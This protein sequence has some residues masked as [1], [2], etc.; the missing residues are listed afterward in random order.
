MLK[1]PCTGHEA[2]I[3]N[4]TGFFGPLA[5]RPSLDVVYIPKHFSQVNST[6]AFSESYSFVRLT[7]SQCD[8]Q[9]YYSQCIRWWFR[10]FRVGPEKEE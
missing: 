2:E 1:S 3:Y 5:S 6:A 8:Q 7:L 10:V 9:N 4:G